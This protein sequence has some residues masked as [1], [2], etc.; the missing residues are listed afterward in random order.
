M[1]HTLYQ[2]FQGSEFADDMAG[3]CRMHKEFLFE[4]SAKEEI[5][6][7]ARHK[8]KDV[9]MGHRELGSIAVMF[10]TIF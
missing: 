1:I 8:L 2:I 4:T 5:T 6:L 10:Q 9:R 3:P 7:K